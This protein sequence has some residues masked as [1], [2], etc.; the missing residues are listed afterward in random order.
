M[1]IAVSPTL[2]IARSSALSLRVECIRREA[3]GVISIELGS[4]SGDALPPWTPGSHLQ[5]HLPSGLVRHYSLCGPSHLGPYR[6]A[7]R[8]EENGRGGS[9]EID[10]NL[11]VGDIV[12][13]EGPLNRFR[14]RRRQ[15]LSVYCRRHRYYAYPSD[16]RKC[17]SLRTGMEPCLLW[18]EPGRH[19]IPRRTRPLFRKSCC[20]LSEE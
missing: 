13:A 19:G 4:P 10:S 20:A 6:I 8:R 11:R 12:R 1:N 16:D 9:R 2:D 15:Q 3:A 5:L 7:V 17:R 18:Q 14:T